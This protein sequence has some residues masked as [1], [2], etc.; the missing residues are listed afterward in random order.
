MAH[1]Q[2]NQ[3]RLLHRVRRLRG[4]I[5]AVERALASQSSCESVLQ[6]IAASRGAINALMAEV[7]EGHIRSHVLGPRVR[8]ASEQGQAAELLIELVDRYLK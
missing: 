2:S 4:Q 1:T 3:A 5:D 6:L 8:P 7:L